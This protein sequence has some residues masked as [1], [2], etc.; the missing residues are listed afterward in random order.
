MQF[1]P[2]QGHAQVNR[3]RAQSFV[4]QAAEAGSQLVVLPELFATGLPRPHEDAPDIAEPASGPTETWLADQALTHRL[5]V[6]GTF[7]EEAE[8]KLRNRLALVMPD[9]VIFRYAK[10]KL[11]ASERDRLTGCGV[12]AG[13]LAPTVQQLPGSTSVK[14]AWPQLRSTKR[15]P[16]KCSRDRRE[17]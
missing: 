5:A 3:A 15:L 1:H 8:G 13:A 4:R 11:D 9:G 17:G 7:L 12:P 16:D 14:R 6:A 10:R 2:V